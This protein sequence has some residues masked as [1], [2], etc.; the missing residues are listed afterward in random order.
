MKNDNIGYQ[1]SDYNIENSLHASTSFVQLDNTDVVDK[2]QSKVLYNDL[3]EDYY[4]IPSFLINDQ[5][6]YNRA[7]PT[8]IDNFNFQF[9]DGLEYPLSF[10]NGS[11]EK[12]KQY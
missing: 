7:Q 6:M 9:N 5:L 1:V 2:I 4:A 11:K 10:Y 3:D 12:S 8:K